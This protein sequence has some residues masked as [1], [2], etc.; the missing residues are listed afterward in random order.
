MSFITRK[1]DKRNSLAAF[2]ANADSAVLAESIEKITGGG[3][4]VNCHPNDPIQVGFGLAPL[5][6]R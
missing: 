3:P 6:Q 2:K 5:L 4:Q 1:H